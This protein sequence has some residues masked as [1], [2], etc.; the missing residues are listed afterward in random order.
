MSW[1]IRAQLSVLELFSCLAP[2]APF[3][4]AL[5]NHLEPRTLVVLALTAVMTSLLIAGRS[6]KF[7]PSTAT[8]YYV[9]FS[10]S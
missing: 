10:N 3:L 5:Q 9:T 4:W 2:S 8:V 6:T 7:G 1:K